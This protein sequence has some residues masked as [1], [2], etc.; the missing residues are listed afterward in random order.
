MSAAAFIGAMTL[1]FSDSPLTASAMTRGA[2]MLVFSVVLF[3]FGALFA[4]ED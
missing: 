3:L 4:E 2:T 1:L